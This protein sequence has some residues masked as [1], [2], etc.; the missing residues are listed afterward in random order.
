MSYS[1]LFILYSI[2]KFFSSKT[3]TNMEDF[4]T[5]LILLFEIA[6]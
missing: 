6:T 2:V 4:P 3:S 5:T 1:V